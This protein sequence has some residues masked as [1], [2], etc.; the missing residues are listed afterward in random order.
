[1]VENKIYGIEI[2]A[3]LKRR[4]LLFVGVQKECVWPL[5]KLPPFFR[6]ERANVLV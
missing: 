2:K 6:E 1:M 4:K 5:D 3:S